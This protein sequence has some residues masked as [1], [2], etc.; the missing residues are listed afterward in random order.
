MGNCRRIRGQVGVAFVRFLQCKRLW[1]TVEPEPVRAATALNQGRNRGL[2][3]TSRGGGLSTPLRKFWARSDP[4]T[5]VTLEGD[6]AGRL[7]PSSL[8]SW[9]QTDPG[10]ERIHLLRGDA[11]S[12]P[13]DGTMPTAVCLDRMR[14]WAEV[15]RNRLSRRHRSARLDGGVRRLRM[16]L[17]LL[18]RIATDE[19]LP[20]RLLSHPGSSASRS[21]LR[22]RTGAR[23]SRWSST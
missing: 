16:R 10:N 3:V 11:E 22:S 18:M 19:I 17:P 1:P 4:G 8:M 5:W 13:I 9:V 20:M 6:H 12:R 15:S 7:G 21:S 2:S 23:R 14:D